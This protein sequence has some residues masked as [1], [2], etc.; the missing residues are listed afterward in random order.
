MSTAAALHQF[1]SDMKK[2]DPKPKRAPLVGLRPENKLGSVKAIPGQRVFPA[3][4]K[5]VSKSKKAG[6]RFPVGRVHRFLRDRKDARRVGAGA[7]VYLTAVLEYLTVELLDI[8][9][10]CA[11][12][13]KLKRITPTHLRQAFQNDPDWSLLDDTPLMTGAQDLPLESSFIRHKKSERSKDAKE[14]REKR[15]AAKKAAEENATTADST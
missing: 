10:T 13:F 14:K 3:K 12:N 15:A 5:S 9:K 2:K 7:S 1:A 11:D 6:L 8:A 4:K